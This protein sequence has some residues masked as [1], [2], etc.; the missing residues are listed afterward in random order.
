MARASQSSVTSS[1][2]SSGKSSRYALA[3]ALGI[4]LCLSRPERVDASLGLIF[5]PSAALPGA[6]VDVHTGGQG[7]LT[8]VRPGSALSVFLAPATAAGSVADTTDSRLVSIGELTV[9]AH[10]NG[11]MT[12]VVPQLAMGDYESFLLC[13]PC[14]QH[15]AGRSLIPTGPFLVGTVA[16]HPQP[17]P[18]TAWSNG[19]VAPLLAGAIVLAAIILCGVLGVRRLRRRSPRG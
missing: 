3:I 19:A 8:V 10:A 7:A 17:Q 1:S 15:S 9:D 18:I 6:M 14:A 13:E 5:V 11:H 2:L 16:N 4:A 12:F